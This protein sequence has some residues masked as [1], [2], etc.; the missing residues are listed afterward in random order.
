MVYKKRIK[1]I[2]LYI[3]LIISLIISVIISILPSY[4][5]I[6]N[7]PEEI[8]PPDIPNIIKSQ[9]MPA[10]IPNLLSPILQNANLRVNNN[11]TDL[12]EWEGRYYL[13]RDIKLEIVP[14]IG[15][16]KKNK[17][18]KIA[19]ISNDFS[20]LIPQKYKQDLPL[21]PEKFAACPEPTTTVAPI[22]YKGA[23]I[24]DATCGNWKVTTVN[25]DG[26][27]YNVIGPCCSYTPRWTRNGDKI[28]TVIYCAPYA[29]G[30]YTML[31]DGTGIT[32]IYMGPGGGTH[33]RY[34]AVGNE[35]AFVNGAQ[36]W[37]MNDDGTGAVAL[38]A[39]G[40]NNRPEWSPDGTKIAY[41][42]T[43]SGAWQIWTMNLNGTGQTQLTFAG[44]NQRARWSPDSAK[45][46]F[47]SD[48]DGNTEI[49]VMNRDGSGQTRV[50][51]NAATDYK[52]KFIVDSSQL[53]FLSNRT[54]CWE[55]YRINIDGTGEVNLTNNC[56]DHN[57]GIRWAP[58]LNKIIFE[59]SRTGNWDV[60]TMNFDGSG[61]T[62]ITNTACAELD[63]KWS[64]SWIFDSF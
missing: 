51:N 52:P 63:F 15:K 53:V 48:R 58:D 42:S 33:P 23:T 4:A 21:K 14:D 29:T 38:A 22:I 47:Y 50:T 16:L 41:A 2:N 34:S 56:S 8:Y 1:K 3:Y 57:W 31:P 9:Y 44:S 6:F 25:I 36:I 27:G 18:E 35:I 26:S 17:G 13:E 39:C 11:I 5:F 10:S 43:C 12:Y 24:S 19:S 55:I 30:Y 32:P 37:K 40:S 64:G 62:N 46:A 54:G 20:S 28:F 7:F 45:I 59:S 60:Y 49:Y 61:Q